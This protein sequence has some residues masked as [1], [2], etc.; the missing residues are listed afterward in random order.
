[1]AMHYCSTMPSVPIFSHMMCSGHS[2]AIPVPVSLP[3][4]VVVTTVTHS[5]STTPSLPSFPYMMCGVHSMAIPVPIFPP[6]QSESFVV[7][8]LGVLSSVCVVSL[9][10][11]HT[12]I[13]Y[14]PIFPIFLGRWC[15]GQ[16]VIP[17]LDLFIGWV[18]HG[19]Y[20]SHP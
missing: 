18:C 7:Q 6:F 11:A 8:A 3:L 15:R 16:C 17:Y 14:F 2:E 4:D 20:S 13:S 12:G 9:E 10:E 19:R 5:G 1:M